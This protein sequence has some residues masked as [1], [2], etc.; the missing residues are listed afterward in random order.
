[1]YHIITDGGC[2]LTQ[3]EMQQHQITKVPFYVSLDQEN[4]MKENVDITTEDFYGRLLADKTLFPKTS[5]CSPQDYLDVMEPHLAAGDDVL[6]I[7]ISSHLSGSH[8]SAVLAQDMASEKYPER[9]IV[10][11]DS[12]MASIAEGLIVIEAARMKEAGFSLEDNV[13]MLEKVRNTTHVYFAPETLE[14]L[15]KGGRVGS[16]QALV[17]GILGMRPILHVVEG[18]VVPLETVRGKKKVLSMIQGSLV[19][20]LSDAKEQV[21]LAL[22]NVLREEDAQTLSD[23]LS[24]DLGIQIKEAAQIGAAI[25]AHTGPGALAIAYC[26]RFEHLLDEEH[27]AAVVFQ[28]KVHTEASVK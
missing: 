28:T 16:T 15:K 23:G 17:G 20:A 21:E 7:T 12:L 18:K 6:L 11:F 3:T 1:M 4:F 10:I 19:H 24:N 5:Q 14:Y 8:Q 9:K 26:K 27:K 13:S 22:G 2:D 25:G